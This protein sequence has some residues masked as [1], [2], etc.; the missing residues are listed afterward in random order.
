M[1][2][3]RGFYIPPI[4][5]TINVAW[6]TLKAKWP[7]SSPCMELIRGTGGGQSQ[8]QQKQF[9]QFNEGRDNTEMTA[10]N[11]EHPYAEQSIGGI[12]EDSFSYQRSNDK[13]RGGS[14][15]S[16]GFSEYDDGGEF[17]APGV[18]INEWQAA[19]NITNAIQGMFIVNLPFAVLRGGYWAIAAMIGIAHIC[20]YTG[21]ILVECLYELD[22]ATGQRVR[23]R[24]SYV[25]I[26]KECFGPTWGARAVNIAQ[27]IELLMTCILY[28]V[29]CGDLM[30]GSFP[31]GAIDTRSWMMLIGIFLIPLG[32]L[33]SLQH[34]SVLSFWCTMAHLLINAIIVGYCILEISDWGWSKVKWDIDMKNFPI[35]LGVIVFSYTSQIFL[36]TL[37]G[38]MIDRSKFDW[39]IN[40]S[41]IA[42]AAFK[43]LFGWICFLTFQ[44]D[45]QQVITNNLHSPSFKGL[46]NF[47][48]VIKAVLSYPLPYYAACELLERAFFR[49]RP[50]TP[51]PT[52]WTVDR[53]LKVWGLAW[54]VGVIVFTILMAI[55][56]PHFGILMGFI[57]SFTGTML[58]FIWPCYFHLKLKRNSMEWGTVAYDCFIIFLG[59]LFGVIGVYDSGSALIEAFE[60]GLP[61]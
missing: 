11:G 8:G 36:P 29:V 13:P 23:V 17:G 18:K 25:A 28:V 27:I 34:V 3:F 50:K 5:A 48:L 54:R 53:E 61:F 33:K 16:G 51:F 7:E 40:W 38:N 15:S 49:G 32:F 46:V 56:I 6:E 57:G 1:A 2:N 22:P 43:S 24:D 52:I 12:A 9:E 44:T 26:A 41:H 20:C 4:G 21:K 19:W 39:M 45:T 60:I 30:I 31:E 47:C 58:S 59:I 55:F 14:T 10:M 35:S 37:E 42:A